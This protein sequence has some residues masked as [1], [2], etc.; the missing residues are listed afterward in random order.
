M[1]TYTT[2]LVYLDKGGDTELVR[3]TPNTRVTLRASTGDADRV[4][5]ALRRS[6]LPVPPPHTLAGSVIEPS[7]DDIGSLW[8][9]LLYP[10]D[11]TFHTAHVELTL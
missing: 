3:Y 6:G 2:S 8:V 9:T 1:T 10:S 5:L 11:Y 4:A 7:D